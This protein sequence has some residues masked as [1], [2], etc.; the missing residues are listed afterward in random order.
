MPRL[1]NSQTLRKV[2][3]PLDDLATTQTAIF[4]LRKIE[5]VEI[6]NIKYAIVD[7]HVDIIQK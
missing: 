2:I 7:I 4:I 6:A 1:V 3:S 5:N